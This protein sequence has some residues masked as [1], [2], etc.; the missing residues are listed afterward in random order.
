MGEQRKLER[1][2]KPQR[3]AWRSKGEDG[4]NK[5]PVLDMKEGKKMTKDGR[6]GKSRKVRCGRFL[7]QKEIFTNDRHFQI[8]HE[9]N[10]TFSII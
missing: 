4:N 10:H 2:R 8:K 7:V 1:E 6:I 5:R 9:P 3:L